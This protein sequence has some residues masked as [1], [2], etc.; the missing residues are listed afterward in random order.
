MKPPVALCVRAESA[1]KLASVVLPKRFRISLDWSLS[2]SYDKIRFYAYLDTWLEEWTDAR[3]ATRDYRILYLD[4]A[5]GHLG[6]DVE[7]YCWQRGYIYLLHYGGTTGIAQVNDTHCHLYVE[8]F[9]VQLEQKFFTKVQSNYPGNINRSLAQVVADVV[10]TW[11]SLDHTVSCEG[12]WATGLANSLNELDQEDAKITGE[13]REVWNAMHM[14]E[15]RKKAFKEVDDMIASGEIKGFED[16][17]KVIVHPPS[18]G[19]YRAGEESEGRLT[20]KGEKS[21][22]TA[23]DV[24]LKLKD[25]ELEFADP[26]T[27][28]TALVAF[29]PG[30]DVVEWSEGNRLAKKL[31]DLR[32]L[33]DEASALA[34][35][36]AC[37]HI[38]RAITNTERGTFAKKNTTEGRVNAVLARAL[39]AEA[40]AQAETRAKNIAE[41]RNSR[42][43]KERAA[44]VV[45]AQKRKK[46]LLKWK[47]EADEKELLNYPFQRSSEACGT[48]KTWKSLKARSARINLL[49]RLRLRSPP[50]PPSFGGLAEWERFRN[51]WA[52]VAAEKYKWQ[53]GLVFVKGINECL[54]QLDCYYAGESEF[55]KGKH[56]RKENDLRCDVERD[57]D[58]LAFEKYVKKRKALLPKSTLTV[59]I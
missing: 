33:R 17:R 58:K 47:K 5:K 13:A 53:V 28:T 27:C 11:R 57:G 30:D 15:E 38:T 4:V 51:C 56:W 14:G 25:M 39:R 35:K 1:Q 6:A 26:A 16:V 12:H 44:A 19:E 32:Q 48:L 45:R 42:K 49:E 31:R 8:D 20:L 54:R 3:A 7:E 41:N 2:G 50:L 29:E 36:P 23:A 24:A 43:K 46:L 55:N 59:C 18:K 9:Y 37:F 40:A 22:E 52:K 10:T 21:W 34:L